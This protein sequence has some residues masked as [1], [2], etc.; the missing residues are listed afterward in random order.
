VKDPF[1]PEISDL[2]V[3]YDPDT[4]ERRPVRK[5][6]VIA[7][8][9]EEGRAVPLRVAEAMSA[10]GGELDAAEID[11]TLVRSHLELQRLHEE[12]R[13]GR[14]ILQLLAPLVALARESTRARPIR[15]CDIGCGLGYVARWLTA[16]GGLGD[17]VEIV[18]V[19]YNRA[20]LAVAEKLAQDERIPCRFLVANAFR[21]ETPAHLYMSTGVLHHFRGEDLVRF[22]R[23]HDR[24]AT[25]GFVH[26]DLRPSWLSPIGSWIFHQARMKEPLARWDGYWSAVRAHDAA[27]L[28]AASRQGAP[29]FHLATVDTTPGVYTP[30]RIFQAVLGVRADR[31]EALRRVYAPLGR[32]IAVAS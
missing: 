5:D 16:S 14:T 30:T 1:G 24:E 29:A 6:H 9:R 11:R 18:G 22:F 3:D 25:V 19:D 12:F 13:V 2:I 21:L 26:V 10:R 15:V 4:L 8:L 27:T 20:L 32:R 17:D 7:R 28:V 31:V 23:E